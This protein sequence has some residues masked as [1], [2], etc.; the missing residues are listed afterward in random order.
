MPTTLVLGVG[1]TLLSD[2]GIGIH[3]IHHLE[4]YHPDI[5]EVTYMD[6]GTLS[7]TLA[8]PIGAADHL[9]VVDAARIDAA[10]GAIRVFS[11]A[12]MDRFLGTGKHSVHE[13][14]LSDLLDISRL[15]DSLPAKRALIGIQPQQLD[16]GEQPSPPVAA[17]IPLAAE[18]IL[19]L[20]QRWQRPALPAC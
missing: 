1:N 4:R 14:G 6:G 18:L 12:A 15:T 5:P 3:V 17:A 7:F 16:W 10:P 13:V 11:D 2:E 9:I 20:I 19:D 8:E